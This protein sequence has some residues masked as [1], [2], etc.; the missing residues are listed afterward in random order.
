MTASTS[1]PRDGHF[2]PTRDAVTVPLSPRT[3]PDP[4]PG[5]IAEP[6]E[7]DAADAILLRLEPSG[8]G[9]LL[10]SDHFY[11]EALGA[12]PAPRGHSDGAG[13][14]SLA[15]E[16]SQ[17]P[18]RAVRRCSSTGL[19][20]AQQLQR[21]RVTQPYTRRVHDV[22][23]HELGLEQAGTH[24]SV[25]C[26]G[27]LECG[28]SAGPSPHV[29]SISNSAVAVSVHSPR[30]GATLAPSAPSDARTQG[31]RNSSAIRPTEDAAARSVR[32]GARGVPGRR[33]EGAP[34]SGSRPPAPAPFPTSS[35]STAT[36]ENR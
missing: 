26:I 14:P 2:A 5:H 20:S 22:S 25:T 11:P 8:S 27:I 10:S 21:F 19:I 4:R 23:E 29:Q 6:S 16:P 34:S 12:T 13:G 18:A 15:R 24:P 31:G 9:A 7:C 32:G 17:L 3:A 36:E 28:I 1:P 33:G 35:T 30:P